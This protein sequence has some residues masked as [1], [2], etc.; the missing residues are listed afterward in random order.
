M[1]NLPNKSNIFGTN[2]N[3]E[4]NKFSKKKTPVKFGP[5]SAY[6]G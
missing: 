2:L 6:F 3:E 5:Y 1:L 4:I